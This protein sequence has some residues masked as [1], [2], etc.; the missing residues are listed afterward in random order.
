MKDHVKFVEDEVRRENQKEQVKIVREA[1][2]KEE[3]KD[4]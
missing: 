1:A 3:Q 4:E 2:K